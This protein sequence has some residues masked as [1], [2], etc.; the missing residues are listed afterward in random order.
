MPLTIGFPALLPSSYRFFLSAK[1]SLPLPLTGD[2]RPVPFS[3]ILLHLWSLSFV[4][5]SSVWVSRRD[6]SK[7]QPWRKVRYRLSPSLCSLSLFPLP[8]CLSSIPRNQLFFESPSNEEN[9]TRRSRFLDRSWRKPADTRIIYGP[10]SRHFSLLTFCPVPLFS[11]RIDI[12]LHCVTRLTTITALPD[13]G[14]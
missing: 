10:V 5:S 12:D 14:R 2:T 6:V 4:F 3:P 9:T 1:I 8:F 7:Y 11:C 13:G